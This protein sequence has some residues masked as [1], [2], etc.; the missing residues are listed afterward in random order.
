MTRTWRSTGFVLLALLVLPVAAAVAIAQEPPPGRPAG[1]R[2]QDDRRAQG[3]GREGAGGEAGRLHGV[4]AQGQRGRDLD[5][6][7]EHFSLEAHVLLQPWLTR[8]HLSINFDGGLYDWFNALDPLTQEPNTIPNRK[9]TV[10][11]YDN[12]FRAAAGPG[13]P[14]GARLRGVDRLQVRGRVR[15][16]KGGAARRLRAAR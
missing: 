9:N 8:E 11:P 12:S 6:S 5:R 13:D 7:G 14:R 2:T 10:Y 1:R 15:R 3:R 16:R 4:D